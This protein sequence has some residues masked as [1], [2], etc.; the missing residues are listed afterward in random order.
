MGPLDCIRCWAYRERRRTLRRERPVVRLA[1]RQRTRP[2]TSIN[3]I[4]ATVMP[5]R[6]DAISTPHAKKSVAVPLRASDGEGDGRQ[7]RISCA[8]PSEPVV[9]D[10][11]PFE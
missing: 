3:P 7:A 8:V 4:R 5:V 2:L 11:H 9:D 10:G 1:M 6:A